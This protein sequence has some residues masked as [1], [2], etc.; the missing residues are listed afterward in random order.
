MEQSNNLIIVREGE[1]ELLEFSPNIDSLLGEDALCF[2]RPATNSEQKPSVVGLSACHRF[3][4]GH[5][6]FSPPS[7]HHEHDEQ[8]FRDSGEAA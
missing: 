8:T 4:D 7:A 6:F 5:G 2:L 3:Q 1:I